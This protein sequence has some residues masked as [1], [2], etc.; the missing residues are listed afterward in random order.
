VLAVDTIPQESVQLL[1]E[2]VQFSARHVLSQEKICQTDGRTVRR[3]DGG[4]T[5]FL[6]EWMQISS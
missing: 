2:S 4:F 1:K 6:L 3:T 5:L